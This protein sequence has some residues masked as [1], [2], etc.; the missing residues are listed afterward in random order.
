MFWGRYGSVVG[1]LFLV[2]VLTGAAL[3]LVVFGVLVAPDPGEEGAVALMPFLGAAGGAVVA[4][5]A[6]V[7]YVLGMS[8]WSRRPDRSVTSRAGMGALS[9]G[10]GAALVCVVY[11]FVTSGG[12]GLAVWWLPALFCAVVAAAT[13]GPLTGRAARLADG[14]DAESAS[15][16]E[17]FSDP[18]AWS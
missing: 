11:G 9:A 10:A 7:S 13:V 18:A 15:L 6:T 3:T 2:G 12:Y 4:A 8:L 5:G 17:P 14:E 16:A 1:W